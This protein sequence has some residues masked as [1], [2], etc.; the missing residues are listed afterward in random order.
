MLKRCSAQWRLDL[1]DSLVWEVSPI[2]SRAGRDPHELASCGEPGSELNVMACNHGLASG[3]DFSG[4]LLRPNLAAV[5]FDR[6]NAPAGFG[7]TSA[8]DNGLVYVL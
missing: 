2:K 1:F 8:A 6:G 7:T 3:V 4:A 5:C